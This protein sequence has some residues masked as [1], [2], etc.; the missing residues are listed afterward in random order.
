MLIERPCILNLAIHSSDLTGP[1]VTF[2]EVPPSPSNKIQYKCNEYS[3]EYLCD[4]V[5]HA[6]N[7]TVTPNQ[8]RSVTTLT[9][10]HL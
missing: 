8:Y 9:I 4:L 2:T 7:I 6:Q 5:E 3:C 10:F 1:V